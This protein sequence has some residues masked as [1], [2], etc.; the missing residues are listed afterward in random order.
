[1]YKPLVIYSAPVDTISG[2]GSRSRDLLKALLKVKGEE[3]D[4]KVLSQR[5][6]NCPFGALDENDEE[7]WEL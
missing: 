3:W 7:I 6:G 4:I 2:Y 1:M 5:W